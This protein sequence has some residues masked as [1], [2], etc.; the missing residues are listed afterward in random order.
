MTNKTELK[1]IRQKA[2]MNEIIKK[3]SN[4]SIIWEETIPGQYSSSIP[5]YD[6]ILTKVNGSEVILD[7]IKDNDIYRSY[8]SSE[9]EDVNSLFEIVTSLQN[10]LDK[11]KRV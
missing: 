3:T 8:K 6:L 5:N 7:V 4:C 9:K 10:T 2:L 1:D 11:N